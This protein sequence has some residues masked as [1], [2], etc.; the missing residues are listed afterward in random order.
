MGCQYVPSIVLVAGM[1][2]SS[3]C[4]GSYYRLL[5]KKT[6]IFTITEKVTTVYKIEAK[7]QSRKE[8]L[9]F[10]LHYFS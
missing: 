10:G 1:A 7:S 3:P 2:Q 4:P 5:R 9:Y 6:L 8:L